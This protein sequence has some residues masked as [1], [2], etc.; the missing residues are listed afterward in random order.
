MSTTFHL[1]EIFDVIKTVK[2][3]THAASDIISYFRSGIKPIKEFFSKID[4]D[5]NK[6]CLASINNINAVLKRESKEISYGFINLSKCGKHSDEYILVYLSTPND[7]LYIDCQLYNGINNLENCIFDYLKYTYN[8]THGID[9]FSEYI[10]YIPM[11]NEDIEIEDYISQNIEENYSEED[12]INQNIEE[13]YSEEDDIND[14][15]PKR[16]KY[17]SHKREERNCIECGGKNICEH[18]RQK[19][20]CI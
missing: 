10:T 4:I 2:D 7:V 8:F 9:A 19:Y 13:D 14:D 20:T 12:D 1:D 5:P 15:I 6:Q 17:C 16:H 3:R 18:K 11:D